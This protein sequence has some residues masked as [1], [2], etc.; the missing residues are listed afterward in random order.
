M[1]FLE[2]LVFGV[3]LG[4]IEDLI[5]VTL[6]THE[7]ITLNVVLIVTIV[8][9]PFAFIGEVIVD[10]VLPRALKKWHERTKMK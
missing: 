10:E 4:V 8:A 6:V 5:A 1:V 9:I 7:P 2:F 3:V